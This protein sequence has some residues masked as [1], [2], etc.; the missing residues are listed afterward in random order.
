MT[1][2]LFADS[3]GVEGESIGGPRFFGITIPALLGKVY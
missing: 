1:L 2:P 3:G